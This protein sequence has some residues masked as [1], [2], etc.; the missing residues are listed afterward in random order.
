MIKVFL[1]EKKVS[2]RAKEIYEWLIDTIG[3]PKN[4]LA[5]NQNSEGDEKVE[6]EEPTWL[7]TFVEG[8]YKFYF[9]K[10]SDAMLFKL[11]WG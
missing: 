9:K 10:K 8:G 1:L 7:Y 2:G 4:S 3:L 11:S 5:V 6:N